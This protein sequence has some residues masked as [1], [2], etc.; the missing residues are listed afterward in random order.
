MDGA[1][2]KDPTWRGRGSH[3]STAEGVG[4]SL[5][6]P[7]GPPPPVQK[8]HSPQ[9]IR[10]TSL[11]RYSPGN[12]RFLQLTRA[13]APPRWTMGMRQRGTAVAPCTGARAGSSPPLVDA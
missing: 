11:L 6:A 12:L 9:L 5:L 4:G 7:E 3:G 2:P 10:C 13:G 8:G 1:S